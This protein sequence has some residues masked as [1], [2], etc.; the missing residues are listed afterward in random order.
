MYSSQSTIVIIIFIAS[1]YML[2]LK[3]GKL[4][5][6]LT[7]SRHFKKN[8]EGGRERPSLPRGCVFYY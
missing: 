8:R 5:M 6:C 7:F 4:P 3:L 1:P 2:G